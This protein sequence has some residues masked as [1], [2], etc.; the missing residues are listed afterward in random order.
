MTKQ[1]IYLRYICACVLYAHKYI[2]CDFLV[3]CDVHSTAALCLF[4]E[5]WQMRIHIRM[6]AA[7]ETNYD[8]VISEIQDNK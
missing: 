4:V 5:K 7:T 8:I 2:D 3:S 6:I 1:I